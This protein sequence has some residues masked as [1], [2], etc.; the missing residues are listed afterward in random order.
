MIDLFPDMP[1]E[2]RAYLLLSMIGVIFFAGIVALGIGNA[3]A[4]LRKAKEYDVTD[5]HFTQEEKPAKP[6]KEK[7]AKA[8]K[9][10]KEKKP[11]FGRKKEDAVELM[12][13]PAGYEFP[14]EESDDDEVETYVTELAAGETIEEE[15]P[16][17]WLT[18][19]DDDDWSDSPKDSSN[20]TENR[21]SQSSSPF[22]SGVRLDSF[23]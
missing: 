12:A 8:V 14:E 9:E 22:G 1:L 20:K 4:N 13:I 5:T 19:D 23:D 3:M 16:D 7:K 15:L 17:D 11:I 2:T 21:G 10:P 6:V 18:S